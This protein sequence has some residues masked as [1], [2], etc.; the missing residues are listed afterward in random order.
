MTK[1]QYSDLL[2]NVTIKHMKF[3][4]AKEFLDSITQKSMEEKGILV[5]LTVAYA[6]NQ[7]GV[8]ERAFQDIVNHA[9]SI[10]NETSLPLSL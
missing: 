10:L 8:T 2:N 1:T 6:H 4:N 9:V 7:N 5:D 3:N